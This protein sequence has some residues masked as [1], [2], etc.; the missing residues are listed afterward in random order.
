ML[1]VDQCNTCIFQFWSHKSDVQNTRDYQQ[2]EKKRQCVK[3]NPTFESL[4]KICKQCID[5]NRACNPTELPRFLIYWEH[6]VKLLHS[7]YSKLIPIVLL[8]EDI[9]LRLL[10]MKESYHFQH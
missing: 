6:K 8:I 10:T 7:L 2:W 9:L 3:S 1:H 5:R 4:N